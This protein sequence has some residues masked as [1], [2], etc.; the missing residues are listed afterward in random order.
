MH[1]ARVKAPA[2]CGSIG[3]AAHGI[4]RQ[5]KTYW[6]GSNQCTEGMGGRNGSKEGNMRGSAIMAVASR[7]AELR[8]IEVGAVGEWDIRVELVSSAISAGTESYQLESR[9]GERPPFIIGYAPIGRVV[10]V[11]KEAGSLFGVGDRVSYFAPSPPA[12]GEENLCGGH[13][14]PAV[15]NVSPATRDLLG[16]DR[17]CVKVPDGLS[18]E[19]AAFAG[20]AAVSSMGA[21]MP[22]PRPGDRALVVGQGVIGQFAMQH[23]RLRGAEVAVADLFE[24]RLGIAAECGADHV[25]NAGDGD[26]VEAVRSIWPE[27][28]DIVADT[29]GSYRVVE[30]SIGAVGTRGKYVF[31]GWCKGKDFELELFH[32]QHVFEAYFPWTLEGRHVLHSMRMMKQ[33]GI[34]VAP[35][36][37]HRFDVADASKAFEMVFNARED[38]VG[39]VFD[40]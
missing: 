1:G 8:E 38:Y 40:W 23:F 39:V 6:T 30:A 33:G 20:I 25:V 34:K 10:E 26:L 22:N 13:Q 16:P 9:G 17:Y 28:A 36:I 2:F 21:T 5:G 14:S 37:T 24:K 15:L 29:T 31:I 19:H 35:I 27:G 7:R 12:S 11:G 32:M 3:G 18:S 4:H